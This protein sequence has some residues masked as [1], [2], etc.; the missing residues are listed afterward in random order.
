MRPGIRKFALTLHITLSV[1]W[2]GAVL[3]YLLLVVA[4]TSL[5]SGLVMSIGTPWAWSNTIG[6]LSR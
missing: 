2:I 6:Y 4:L 5:A 1:G 3:A